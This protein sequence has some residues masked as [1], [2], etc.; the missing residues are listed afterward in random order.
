MDMRIPP[1]KI[2]I[3]L[4]SNR[5]PCEIQNL[6][7]EMG[8]IQG[9]EC[10]C[11]WE[12]SVGLDSETRDYGYWPYNYTYIYIYIYIAYNMLLLLLLSLCVWYYY[13]YHY[14]YI[15]IC[16]CVYMYVY[17][18]IYIYIYSHTLPWLPYSTLSANSV[19]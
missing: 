1:L 10:R 16:I 13:Y 9:C 8:H 17:L 7:T 15:Y 3:L 14:M 5:K 11:L 12:S 2:K 18:Y 4:E 6:S 19:K